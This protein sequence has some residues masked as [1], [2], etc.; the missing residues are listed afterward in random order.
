[1][2]GMTSM[3]RL[4]GC[5]VA[6]WTQPALHGLGCCFLSA[7]DCADIKSAYAQI[8]WGLNKNN[9]DPF[10]VKPSVRIGEALNVVI[11]HYNE[12]TRSFKQPVYLPP[13]IEDRLMLWLEEQRFQWMSFDKSR[14]AIVCTIQTADKR[15]HFYGETFVKVLGLALGFTVAQMEEMPVGQATTLSLAQS[16]MVQ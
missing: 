3:I 2:D 8:G 7:K 1:M 4:I 9:G 16:A 12:E 5:W 10:F 14:R 15:Q 6:I 13:E 11:G